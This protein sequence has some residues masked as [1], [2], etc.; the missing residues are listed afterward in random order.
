MTHTHTYKVSWY[1]TGEIPD[2]PY[3]L[4]FDTQAEAQAADRALRAAMSNLSSISITEQL[5]LNGHEFT[6]IERDVIQYLV[7]N[8]TPHV[9]LGKP[10]GRSTAARF[11]REKTNASLREVTDFL[12]QVWP[13][14]HINPCSENALPVTGFSNMTHVG[15]LDLPKGVDDG[16]PYNGLASL[17]PQNTVDADEAIH[18]RVADRITVINVLANVHAE[19]TR[20]GYT[21]YS[22]TMLAQAAQGMHIKDRQVLDAIDR[23]TKGY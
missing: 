22:D 10:T 19:L 1:L 11:I 2:R 23:L 8:H 21:N 4:N 17:P 15:G 7:D 9:S 18:Q 6:K 5:A 12:N 14:K 16:G 3:F 20:K 13:A